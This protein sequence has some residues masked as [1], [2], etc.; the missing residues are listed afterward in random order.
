VRTRAAVREGDRW[1][2]QGGETLLHS[3]T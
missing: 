3:E 1:V 2:E